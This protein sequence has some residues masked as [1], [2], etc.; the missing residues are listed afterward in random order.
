MSQNIFVEL[1]KRWKMRW[2]KDEAQKPS[3]PKVLNSVSLVHLDSKTLKRKRIT[4]ISPPRF[5]RAEQTDFAFEKSKLSIIISNNRQGAKL[6]EK[7]D[8]ETCLLWDSANQRML[9][10]LE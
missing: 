4:I 8:D 5:C 10:M 7:G 3:N 6:W 9:T 2:R 1:R